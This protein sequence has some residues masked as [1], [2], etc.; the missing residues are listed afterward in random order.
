MSKLVHKLGQEGTTIE[1]RKEYPPHDFARN[2]PISGMYD[3]FKFSGISIIFLRSAGA[4]RITSTLCLGCGN[5][6]QNK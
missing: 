4:I 5:K 2:K 1:E 6:E 3:Q